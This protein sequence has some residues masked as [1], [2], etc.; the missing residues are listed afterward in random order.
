MRTL[1]IAS[2]LLLLAPA[3]S[4][5]DGA[6][7]NMWPNASPDG[8]EIAFATTRDGGDWEIYV[9]DADGTNPRRLTHSPGRDAHPSFSRSG[10]QIF[11]QS[12]RDYPDEQTEVAI[13]VMDRDGKGQRRL[14]EARGA[15]TG[16]PVPSRGG[17]RL[18]FMR[19]VYD[20]ARKTHHWELQLAES[21][22]RN[23]VP[24]T[25]NAWN[26]QVPSWFPG[27]R[28]LAFFADPAGREQLFVLD[29]AS[30]RARPL[31]Q[32]EWNDQNPSV[33]PDGRWIAFVSDRTGK[34]LRDLH[35]DASSR[36]VR[37]LTQ[38]FVL[39]SQPNWSPRGERL[40]FSASKAGG[41]DEIYGILPDGSGLTRLTHG[42]EGIR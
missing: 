12:P 7:D 34:D 33:S 17:R 18:A 4:R 32:S 24:L 41:V 22:G 21:S 23:P 10:Q 13:Y 9:M 25:D 5:A 6:Y 26:S 37:P 20:A 28:E 30:R 39:R 35:V 15:F 2:V 3:S 36:R 38:G 1:P 42:T 31:L 27:D 40:F 14:I 8:K 16:V 11:F 29:V 19:G